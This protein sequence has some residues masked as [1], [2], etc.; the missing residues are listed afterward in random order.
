M[1]SKKHKISS[2]LIHNRRRRYYDENEYYS[3]DYGDTWFRRIVG[4]P[5]AEIIIL[6]LIG[7]VKG[8]EWMMH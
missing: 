2:I 7:A 6:I 8:I 4:L 5:I 3:K 1:F